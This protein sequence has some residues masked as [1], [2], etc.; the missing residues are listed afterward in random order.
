MCWA[1]AWLRRGDTRLRVELAAA[2]GGGRALGPTPCCQAPSPCP[3]AAASTPAPRGGHC[4]TE[5]AGRPGERASGHCSVAPES[6]EQLQCPGAEAAPYSEQALRKCSVFILWLRSG[7]WPW[8][9][10]RVSLEG[11]SSVLQDQM[12]C[13][14]AYL[15]PFVEH[16]SFWTISGA[17][18]FQRESPLP[19]LTLVPLT[20]A[21]AHGRDAGGFLKRAVRFPGRVRPGLGAPRTVDRARPWGEAGPERLG[22]AVSLGALDSVGHRRAS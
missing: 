15:W 3:R 8:H 14:R 9:G 21:P 16:R 7:D 5:R 11:E 12:C 4:S 18:T 6:W 1:S 13:L 22:Q 20:G 10:H 2:Q 19:N 17:P